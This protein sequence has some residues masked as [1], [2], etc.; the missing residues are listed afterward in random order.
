[1][2]SIKENIMLP[3]EV[4]QVFTK[5]SANIFSDTKVLVAVSGGPDSMLTSVLIYKYFLE[6]KFSLNNLFFIHC[7]H[8]TRVET[9]DE[10]K[11]IRSFF[12]GLNLDVC[13]YTWSD[14]WENALRE[15]R[16]SEFNEVIKK[17]KIDFLV[18]GHNLTDR[19]ESTFMNMCRGAWLYWFLSMKFVDENNLIDWAKILRPLLSFTKKQIEKLCDNQNI[20]YVVDHTNF[21][22]DTSFRN[23]I[24][25]SI[26][27]Q[28]AEISNKND[29]ISCS[30]FE[31]MNKIY[32]DIESKQDKLN[33]WNFVEIKKSPY[34]N[35]DFAFLREIPFGFI[36]E[37]VLLAVLRKFNVYLDVTKKTL[38]DFLQ[39]FHKAEQWY[40]YINWAYFFISNGKIYIIK[41]KQ[42]FWEKYIEKEI[43]IDKVWDV[44]IW[45]NSVNVDS[46]EFIWKA[47]RYP[48]PGDKSGSK[49]WWKYCINRKIPIFWRN[50]VPVVVEGNQIV[51]SFDWVMRF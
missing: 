42:N 46:Q 37:N 9:D 4:L 6:N 22:Q 14:K 13:Q 30:F 23:K 26:L 38:D 29:E 45:K 11:F 36:D 17:N 18:T 25:L 20:P 39:F 44:E 31:S 16:Y 51:N 24:R 50:F 48:K 34:R 3:N 33:I 1:M 2:K 41:A 47:L 27:P 49:S 28:L 12:D 15:W 32:N 21:D 10:E 7:N 19:I 43:I 5:L 8:K 40:K 35:A